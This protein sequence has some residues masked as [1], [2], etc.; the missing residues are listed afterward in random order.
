MT[1]V[2][3]EKLKFEVAYS[4]VLHGN[5]ITPPALLIRLLIYLIHHLLLNLH[6]PWLQN[7]WS[8]LKTLGLTLH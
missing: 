3:C 5:E 4:G 7:A 6:P 1:R 8:L 2:D